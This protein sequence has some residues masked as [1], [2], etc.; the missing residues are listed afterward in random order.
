MRLRLLHALAAHQHDLIKA[1]LILTE[2]F[3]SVFEIIRD[4]LIHVCE[5]HFIAL[6]RRWLR[7]PTGAGSGRAEGPDVRGATLG[8]ATGIV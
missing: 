5:F 4:H 1:F 2:D 6:G 7:P 3:G 8:V